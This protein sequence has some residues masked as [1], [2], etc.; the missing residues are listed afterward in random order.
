MRY[1]SNDN[2]F[3]NIKL[4]HPYEMTLEKNQMKKFIYFNK[5]LL[6]FKIA[7]MASAGDAKIYI[8][9]INYRDISFSLLLQYKL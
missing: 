7:E 1:I 3:I 8:M 2:P 6:G 9:P 5:N 4:S